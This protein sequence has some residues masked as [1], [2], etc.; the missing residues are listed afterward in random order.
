MGCGQ[1]KDSFNLRDKY[2]E[3]ALPNLWSGQYQNEFE[4][5]IYMA[6]NLVRADPKAIS[7]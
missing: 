5:E 4:K 3:K 1:A 6:I 2:A 7:R